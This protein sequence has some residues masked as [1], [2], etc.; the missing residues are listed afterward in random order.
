MKKNFR[1]FLTNMAINFKIRLIPVKE[2]P[3]VRIVHIAGE[4]DESSIDSF[5]KE[6]EAYL[7]TEGVNA[8]IFFIRD[9]EFINSMVVGYFAELYTAMTGQGRKMIFAEGNNKIIDILQVVGFLN[10]VD[11]HPTVQEAMDSLDF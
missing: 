2:K 5:K 9:L 7:K 6:V 10:L 4:I 1:L 3:D 8:F 11:Y